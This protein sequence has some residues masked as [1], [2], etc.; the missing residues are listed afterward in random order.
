MKGVVTIGAEGT[1]DLGADFLAGID[2]LE[3]DLF[4]AGEVLV[5]LG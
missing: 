4:E 1:L 2:I 5:S 3:D